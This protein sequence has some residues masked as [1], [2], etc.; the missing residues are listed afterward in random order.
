MQSGFPFTKFADRLASLVE[1]SSD[2]VDLL[3]KM[4]ATIGHF[5][6]RDIVARKGDRPTVCCLLLQGYLCWTV[7]CESQQ[8]ITSLHVPG[9]IPDLQA[10]SAPLLQFDLTAFGPVVV[11]FVPHRFFREL[12]EASARLSRALSLLMLTDVWC[13]RNWICNLATRDALARVAHLLCEL[14]V[15][16]QAIGQARDF[17]FLSP[18]TQTDLAA[19]CA[20]SAVH[21][22]RTIQELRRRKLLQWNSRT[23]EITDWSGLVRL[24]GFQPDYLGLRKPSLQEAKDFNASL[25]EIRI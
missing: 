1:L 20:I 8:Q 17:R 12:S 19:A 2:D 16:L 7:D 13:L 5:G 22:N 10:L 15:R 25:A 24:A 11:A 21:A 6:S 23:I 3:A 18:F 4:P 9:D 14:T